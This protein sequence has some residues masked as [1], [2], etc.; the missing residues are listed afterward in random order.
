[1]ERKCFIRLTFACRCKLLKLHVYSFLFYLKMLKYAEEH[2]KLFFTY[3]MGES[4]KKFSRRELFKLGAL[5]TGAAI[6]ASNLAPLAAY[7]S[8]CDDSKITMQGYVSDASK[9]DS[10]NKDFAKFETHKKSILDAASK[11]KKSVD[12]L[13]PNCSNC[14]QYKEKSKG[15][16]LCPM[17]GANGQPGK[18][19]KDTGWCKV[20]MADSSKLK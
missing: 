15:C 5:T 20:Y 10:K 3:F 8:D 14:K 1:M 18:L 7:A 2:I 9:V 12:K 17:V 13:L 6:L 19:V 11:A 4:M 16:G